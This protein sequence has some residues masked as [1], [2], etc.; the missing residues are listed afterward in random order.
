[1]IRKLRIGKLLVAAKVAQ[2]HISAVNWYYEIFHAAQCFKR[3]RQTPVERDQGNFI[4]VI[5]QPGDVRAFWCVPFV[6]NLLANRFR[7]RG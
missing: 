1:M 3:K 4:R 2:T 5:M 7:K 6:E